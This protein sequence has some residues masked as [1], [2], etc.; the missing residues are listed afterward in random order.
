MRDAFP[1]A[2]VLEVN[3][4]DL[5]H[6]KDFVILYEEELLF[7]ID[8][9]VVPIINLT[10][11]GPVWPDLLS[12]DFLLSFFESGD[13]FIN[14]VDNTMAVIFAFLMNDLHVYLARLSIILYS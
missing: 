2:W 9:Q 3:V 10:R 7:L 5:N 14:L 4:R 12:S 13:F 1:N 8:D 11:I 6:L